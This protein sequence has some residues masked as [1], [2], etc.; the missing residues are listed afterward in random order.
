[1]PNP[2]TKKILQEL[3]AVVGLP[4]VLTGDV[5]LSVYECDAE[6]LDVAR[7]DCVVLP[8]NTEQVAKIVKIANKYQIPFSPRGAGTGLSGGATTIM[9]GISLVLTRLNKILK[10]DENQKIAV[11]QVGVT[12]VSV[13]EAAHP[14]EL[15]FAPDPSSQLASTIG[16]NIAENAGGPHCLKY[17]MTTNHVLGMTVVL[18]DGA[19]VYLG[20]R[21]RPNQGL[22]LLG[23][24]IGS[25]GTLGIVTEA[26]LNLV[27]R[28]Q[29]VETMVSY[30]SSVEDAGQCV[31]DII[32]HGVV[33][34][35]MEL[36]DGPTLNAVEDAFAMGL[37]RSA[38]ALL[39]VELD[40]P[41]TGI[42]VHKEI[43]EACSHKNKVMELHWAED[44]VTRAK[45]W[46]ARKSAFAAYGRIA[47]HAYVLDGVIPRSKL[48]E[49]LRRIGSIAEK[50]QLT[51]AN[52]CHAGDGNMHPCILFHRDNADEL[53]RVMLAG[54]E[55]LNACVEFGGTLSGEHGIGIEKVSEMPELFSD[56]DLKAMA[57]FREAFNPD[58]ICN[59]GKVLPAVKNCGESGMR[60]LLRYSIV[61]SSASL[62]AK[63]A[64]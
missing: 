47:P 3:Q 13:S 7:P 40:G 11:V 22:D 39:I 25:E 5:D 50:Y 1:M 46:K 32:A 42:T 2:I 55:I 36:I 35:A 58:G 26:T 48:A 44:L 18:P 64:F 14:F 60:A 49:M 17:G 54:R 45:I 51:I 6:T 62:I 30:F 15:Y 38:R 23:A 8:A 61:D 31:A 29:A 56:S 16:G 37:L 20:G 12:N 9:G 28:P 4:Y 43:V 19:I 10:I 63:G 52:V 41:R 24:F 33:P 27:P 57:S 53:R 59:P 34:A 21:T